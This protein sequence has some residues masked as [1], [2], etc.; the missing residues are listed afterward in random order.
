MI[1][2]R[3]DAN[4]MIGKVHMKR[5]INIARA[6]KMAGESVLFVT[7]E[8]SDTSMLESNFIDFRLV[9][10]M[11]L[12]SE[13]AI[14]LLKDIITEVDSKT[15]VIDSYD[16]SN[17]AFKSLREICKVVLIEDYYYETYDVDCIINYNLY[18]NKIDYMSKYS[19]NVELL[20]GTDYAPYLSIG[21]G[22]STFKKSYDVN[23]IL[24]YTGEIDTHELAP[25]IVECLL[26]TVDDN[27]R[28][29]VMTTK[30]ATTRDILYKMSN[31]SSQIII[32]QDTAGFDKLAKICDMAVTVADQQCY[33]L[34]SYNMPCCVYMSD[35]SQ[36]MLFN[37]LTDANLMTYGGDYVKKSG[38]FYGE[39]CDGV[40]K[41]LEIDTLDMIRENIAKLNLG[42]GAVH[43]ADAIMKYEK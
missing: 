6:V 29:R 33:D 2:F 38:K 40:N 13:K 39:L 37:S 34:L 42:K 31:S 28:I 15:V 9:P 11:K 4:S 12:G 19:S 43:I 23:S 20:L 25:G 3:V 10:S 36:N 30:N 18:A 26:D 22:V 24:V 35:Y 32:E 16:V 7:R 5:C 41:L 14:N 21:A 17:V 8:D 1:V 27:V